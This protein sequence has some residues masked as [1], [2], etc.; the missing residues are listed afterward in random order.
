[1][2]KEIANLNVFKNLK[3]IAIKTSKKNMIKK[4]TNNN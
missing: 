4:L 1:M 2:K 3:N